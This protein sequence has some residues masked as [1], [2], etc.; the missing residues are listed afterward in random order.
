MALGTAAVGGQYVD[1]GQ[2]MTTESSVAKEDLSHLP[3]LT[4]DESRH[5]TRQS[6]LDADTNDTIPIE[7]Q[8]YLKPPSQPVLHVRSAES[9]DADHYLDARL[10]PPAM[11]TRQIRVRFRLLGEEAPRIRADAE[12]E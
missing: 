8:A 3:Q 1:G 7:L 9:D 11:E 4:C 10:V 12:I 6:V 2:P 5:P